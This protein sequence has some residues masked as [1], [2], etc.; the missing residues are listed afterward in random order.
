MSM[1]IDEILKHPLFEGAKIVVRPGEPSPI[2]GM[3]TASVVR[4]PV[5]SGRRR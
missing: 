5:V 1:T 4:M 3:P 2:P